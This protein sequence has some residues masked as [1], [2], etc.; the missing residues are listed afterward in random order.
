[1][2]PRI[3]SGSWR[4]SDDSTS[5]LAGAAGS[6]GSG[7]SAASV[8]APPP[9]PPLEPEAS[10]PAPPSLRDGGAGVVRLSPVHVGSRLATG[11]DSA[12]VEQDDDCGCQADDE[13]GPRE[14]VQ[15]AVR[16]SRSRHST[17]SNPGGRASLSPHNSSHDAES[18]RGHASEGSVARALQTARTTSDL[19]DQALPGCGSSPQ[20]SPVPPPRCS[21]DENIVAKPPSGRRPSRRQQFAHRT[22]DSAPLVVSPSAIA[23]HPPP[24]SSGSHTELQFAS[25][26]T[27]TPLNAEVLRLLQ[28]HDCGANR[29]SL[30]TEKDASAVDAAQATPLWQAAPWG[31]YTEQ[32]DTFR[33]LAAKLW[34]T[35][36]SNSP[37]PVDSGEQGGAFLDH[38]GRLLAGASQ[39]TS[40]DDPL[41]RKDSVASS[42]DD[43]LKRVPWK[44]QPDD[45]DGLFDDDLDS[46]GERPSRI[47]L[48]VEKSQMEETDRE[49]IA[50]FRR[51]R[52]TS[53]G[54]LQKESSRLMSDAKAQERLAQQYV[55]LSDMVALVRSQMGP[56]RKGGSTSMV[57]LMTSLRLYTQ[58]LM[59]CDR[60]SLF[61]KVKKADGYLL[62]T[63]LDD[64]QEITL[65]L[66]SG[67]A[68]ASVGSRAAV[69]VPDAYA[70][71]RFN[72]EVDKFT[73]YTTR[74]VLCMPV[75]AGNETDRENRCAQ[76][77]DALNGG[78]PASVAPDEPER[79]TFAKNARTMCGKAEPEA[80]SP[81]SYANRHDDILGVLQVINKRNKQR[82]SFGANEAI[83][84]FTQEDEHVLRSLASMSAITILV[85]KALDSERRAKDRFAAL[86]AMAKMLLKQSTAD[87]RSLY[88]HIQ[89]EAA[90]LCQCEHAFIYIL[91]ESK[92]ILQVESVAGQ[93]LL[94][95]LPPA[96]ASAN[97]A[98]LGKR[99]MGPSNNFAAGHCLRTGQTVSIPDVMRDDRWA[100]CVEQRRLGLETLHSLVA[101]PISREAPDGSIEL[102]GVLEAVNKK[103]PKGRDLEFDSEDKELLEGLCVYTAS[104]LTTSMAFKATASSYRTVELAPADQTPAPR[105]RQVSKNR[106]ESARRQESKAS[107]AV[108]MP[109]N[110]E[111][112]SVCNNDIV[113]LV[114]KMNPGA[115]LLDWGFNAI[116]RTDAELSSLIH[117]VFDAFDLFNDFR[118]NET[119]L[120]SFTTQVAQ[121][122]FSNPFHCYAHAW[123][124]L[125]ACVHMVYQLG[126]LANDVMAK[127]DVLSLFV[128][129]LC[130]DLGHPG[131]NNMFQQKIC[132]PLALLYNDESILEN[133]HAA[134]CFKLLCSS[135]D[136]NILSSLS[137]TEF[138]TVRRFIC[139]S[140][141]STDM[142]RHERD[143][144]RLRA[145]LGTPLTKA[146]EEDRQ[147]TVS[148]VLHAADLS[149]P[150]RKPDLAEAWA[151]LL[152]EEFKMQAK[153]EEEAG[154]EVSTFMLGGYKESNE[155]F[156]ITTFVKP[157][158]DNLACALPPLKFYVGHVNALLELLQKRLAQAEEERSQQNTRV[159][160]RSNSYVD[161]PQPAS[162]K[163]ASG[164][165]SAGGTGGVAR[166]SGKSTSFVEP[167]RNDALK[168]RLDSKEALE[169]DCGEKRESFQQ[170]LP[171]ELTN[172]FSG[173]APIGTTGQLVRRRLARNAS[174]EV[175]DSEPLLPPNVSN[176]SARSSRPAPP[177]GLHL[178]DVLDRAVSPAAAS[179]ESV[180][181]A[182]AAATPVSFTGSTSSTGGM[183]SPTMVAAL[184]NASSASL[185]SPV[186]APAQQRSAA[187]VRRSP[188]Q[189][190]GES[191]WA[192]PPPSA[193]APADASE[194]GNGG[195]ISTTR[196]ART[197]KAPEAAQHREPFRRSA[198]VEASNQAAS[199]REPGSA[200]GQI[201]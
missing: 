83:A 78:P 67:L 18:T 196:S 169:S 29:P 116:G 148:S 23:A 14:D 125:Q 20:R 2:K 111:M 89:S 200:E 118:I 43:P 44:A 5:D 75:L 57:E 115:E 159:D 104:A 77:E 109:F 81:S 35:S 119:T 160:S 7:G 113:C 60:C 191:R 121:G 180:A 176:E 97:A 150:A 85:T 62:W 177:G 194:G 123:T 12:T 51:Q 65:P 192:A 187:P 13:C 87:V 33:G 11:G 190:G 59:S 129:A 55:M 93:Q 102:I 37:P 79:N 31:D 108:P 193:D 99:G 167:A 27:V 48:R 90:R 174:D 86:G 92:V 140:I 197:P 145:H 3:T 117:P 91:D 106:G 74:S 161:M 175:S 133:H 22:G 84:T 137:K 131:T 130:H 26:S 41:A 96:W 154:V 63:M 195:P 17:V 98:S 34:G 122:Y 36:V 71:P 66:L 114:E 25:L 64:G 56:D 30:K 21:T 153:K 142:S 186:A 38:R 54:R 136:V 70:D 155:I 151:R 146:S 120:S 19:E 124:V 183:P 164:K 61:I 141:L 201:Q 126:P 127:V 112:S 4:A 157:M 135:P 170:A 171:D 94:L 39:D 138:R 24:V 144:A 134:S 110:K 68:G 28:E 10:P 40:G 147:L 45:Y 165:E 179:S 198:V 52:R 9:P 8:G 49:S 88:R 162:L 72:D 132:S 47:A 50:S 95:R 184:S 58:E 166:A 158:W 172:I 152:A 76:A 105:Q 143:L 32:R 80:S 189:A 149:N 156:F 173:T 42:I 181:G 82:D 182:L 6:A 139:S 53:I 100:T 185:V 128:A 73:G 16:R 178:P 188:T 199:T 103:D 101:L 163:D 168:P 15:H 107:G 69:R 46:E 1:M